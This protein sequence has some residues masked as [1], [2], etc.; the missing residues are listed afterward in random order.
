MTGS[1]LVAVLGRG[2]V[3][4]SAPVLL[5]DDFGLTRG[6][7]CFDATRVVTDASGTRVDNLD[8]HLARLGRSCRILAM[9]GFDPDAWLD[10]VEQSVQAWRTPGEATLKLIVTR[11]LEHTPPPHLTG[12][13]TITPLDPVGIH[14]RQGITIAALTRGYA[15]DAFID[16]PWLLGGAKTLSYAVNTAARREASRRGADDVL[17]MS[18]DGKAL[19]GPTSALV[20]AK[21]GQL[22]TTQHDGTGILASITQEMVFAHAEDEGVETD[23]VLADLATVMDADA[24]WMLSSIRGV[25][26]ITAI[27]GVPVTTDAGLTGR[28]NRWARFA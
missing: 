5:A 12:I 27:D 24:S 14:Q 25:A 17:F 8:A 2:V 15:S 19:E 28:I 10:L 9:E 22:F 21:D 4:A 13:L 16:A 3:D 6:D 18:T 26:P 7:G 1:Q 20:W 11:G 23:Y